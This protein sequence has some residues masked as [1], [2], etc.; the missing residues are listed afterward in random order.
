[1][2]L[3]EGIELARYRFSF[4]ITEAMQLPEYAGSAL[5]GVFGRALMQLSGLQLRDIKEKTPLF[6]HS[7][8]AEIFEPQ[9][10]PQALG[11]LAKLQGTPP[12][13]VVEAP[14]EGVRFLDK[15]EN[16]A[17]SAVLAGQALT[18][19]PLVILA[20]R[21]ALLMGLGRGHA[22][23]AELIR[24]EH[25]QPDG[26]VA[27]IYSEDK[28]LVQEHVTLLL[29][30]VVKAA[31]DVHLHF[32][33]PLRLQHNGKVLGTSELTPSLL[34]RQLVRRMSIYWQM[35]Q[36]EAVD[37]A[38]IA[39]LNA[40]ADSV[41]KDEKR[42]SFKRWARYSSRQQ[43]LMQMDGVQGHWLLRN[44]PVQMQQLLW[45]GQYLHVGK[46]TAFGLGG[47]VISQQMWQPLIRRNLAD[48]V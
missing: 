30:P 14:T 39:R 41:T 12:L 23:R 4:R 25:E 47:Y 1:M 18:H 33:T 46:G 6:L 3:S 7:P 27:C 40:L 10:N 5:R 44:V 26:T 29:P 15:G 43:Q 20:W 24:V 13:Y 45:Y 16:L 48:A 11:I 19:L 8:Y 22:G 35:Q 28:P 36:T 31:A 32:L 37:V 38:V 42:L 21:R 34:L 9:A 17:F 2:Q